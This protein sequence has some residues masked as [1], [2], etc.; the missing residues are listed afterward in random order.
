[1]LYADIILPL[2]PDQLFTYR[3]PEEFAG[4]ILPG[5]R[6]VVQ[7]G[8]RKYYTGIIKNLHQNPAESQEYKDIETLPDDKPIVNKY[9]LD[10]WDWLSDYYMCS[11]G[12]IF[13]AAIPSGLKPE[14]EPEIVYN[15]DSD[16]ITTGRK[17]TDLLLHIIRNREKLT[18][19]ELSHLSRIKN[20]YPD[21]KVLADLDAVKISEKIREPAQ[22]A[23]EKYISLCPSFH[24]PQNLHVLLDTLLKAPK[25]HELL[26][27]FLTLAEEK[28][29][30]FQ[31]KYK[32]LV[33]QSS[34]QA[35]SSLIKKGV[36]QITR[37]PKSEQ[38][39]T[40]SMSSPVILT[41]EQDDAYNKIQKS[42]DEKDVC[43]LHGVT[44]S[45]KTEIY[46]HLISSVLQKGKH[47][48]YL[49]PE[50]ALT[51]QIIERLRAVFGDNVGIYH[52]RFSDAERINV[53]NRMNSDTGNSF[54]IILGARSS[55]FLPFNNLGL[56]IVDEEHENSYKQFDP[57]P[58]Y[59]ARDAAI[60]LA[61]L[62]KAKVILGTATPSLE[63]WANSENGKY[64]IVQIRNRFGDIKLPRVIIANIRE[65]ARKNKMKSVFTPLL[66]D[67]IS[68]TISG[69]KQVI[70]FQNRRGYSS[71]LQC[72]ECSWIPRC[73]SCDVSLTYHKYT[74]NLICH[75][76]GFS[77]M[78][79]A[80][81][82]DCGSSAIT[83]KGFG[84][85]LIEDEI[86]LLVKGVKT[87]RLD[88]DTSRPVRAYEKILR[89]FSTGKTNILIG[90]QMISKGLDFD[91]VGL[92][93]IVNADQMLNYP[94]FR[95]Y[96]RSFQLMMQVS[97]RAGRRDEQGK[98]IIQTYDPS[99][100][101]IRYVRDN[102]SEGF[103]HEQ[104]VERQTFHYPPFVKMIKITLKHKNHGKVKN[105]ALSLSENMRNLFGKRVLGP[106]DPV[107]GRIQSY[108]LKNIILKI[109]KS[110]SFAKARGHLR[111]ILKEFQLSD[112]GKQIKI[113]LDVD[114]L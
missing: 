63:T 78:V 5:M 101:I 64:G 88:L 87:A 111:R 60:M 47:I 37:K 41:R 102:D 57:S 61:K 12:E 16:P 110:A 17:K 36:F 38:C 3:V 48:L 93:G 77:C 42:F 80:R 31:V 40:A 105:A 65:T 74:D 4:K 2:L 79:P 15:P 99:N 43:L 96:E 32:A 95:A 51:S 92:V 13:K 85:E 104:L 46:I 56:V 10:F 19:T 94:D 114:P 53:Y 24:N 20:V 68:N 90:T 103:L 49:L 11:L 45:G 81:C 9:Q 109:E 89:D 7:F 76:C 23:E 8:K 70:L 34:P 82:E 108:Y 100:P 30:D 18:F 73:K 26:I 54:S 58:R 59:H 72:T 107:I 55:I 39:L 44:S 35:V 25:Q 1:M 22:P 86:E 113:Q 97:G 69:G 83:T 50:I 27:R 14:S 106:Q 29:I 112:P 75:Y 91:N 62:H 33:T 66:I 84:T 6:A 67:E 71:Y 52:S 28:L 21:V 98:V